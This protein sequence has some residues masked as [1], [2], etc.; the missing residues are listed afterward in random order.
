MM[1]MNTTSR[2]ISFGVL[3]QLLV[4]I[5]FFFFYPTV[6]DIEIP[7]V[8]LCPHHDNALHLSLIMINL[9]LTVL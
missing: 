9:S 3:V 6:K 7:I 8:L 4:Q 5:V 1:T 2:T